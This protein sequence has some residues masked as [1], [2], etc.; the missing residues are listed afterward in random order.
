MERTVEGLPTPIGRI[1]KESVVANA[2]PA[3]VLW[4]ITG[5]LGS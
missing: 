3:L 2:V 4:L 5:R 1:I